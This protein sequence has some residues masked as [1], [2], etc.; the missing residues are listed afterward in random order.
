MEI[1]KKQMTFPWNKI[2]NGKKTGAYHFADKVIPVTDSKQRQYNLLKYVNNED[3]DDVR[4]FAQLQT[5]GE[6]TKGLHTVKDR[7]DIDRNYV[8]AKSELISGGKP[9]RCIVNQELIDKINEEGGWNQGDSTPQPAAKVFE[10]GNVCTLRAHF[11]RVSKDSTDTRLAVQASHQV[12][13]GY[14]DDDTVASASK[15]VARKMES[16]KK[17]PEASTTE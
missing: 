10:E 6:I 9:T 7:N 14:L 15:L 2:V 12:N 16:I 8:I 5:E 1:S 17:V 4:Y 11:D 3:K 13:S